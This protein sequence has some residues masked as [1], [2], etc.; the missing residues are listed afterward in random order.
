MYLKIE[1]RKSSLWVLTHKYLKSRRAEWSGK[2]V[3][4]VVLVQNLILPIHLLRIIF[5]LG[6]CHQKCMLSFNFS[7]FWNNECEKNHPVLI[8]ILRHLKRSILARLAARKSTNI[9]IIITI[10]NNKLNSFYSRAFPVSR[11][12]P[13]ATFYPAHRCQIDPDRWRLVMRY[14]NIRVHI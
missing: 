10:I 12:D 14:V 5:C 6:V 4:L 13:A 3:I 1:F 7:S 8:H 11:R 2:V 9:S